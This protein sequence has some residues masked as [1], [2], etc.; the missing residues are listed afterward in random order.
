MNKKLEFKDNCS[1]E[2]YINNIKINI[3]NNDIK[4]M[5]LQA[6][7]DALKNNL[8]LLEQLTEEK[9]VKNV[10]TRNR[11]KTNNGQ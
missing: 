8:N 10:R 9:E 3:K 7:N 6:E 11:T 1:L 5:N 4:I 2:Q